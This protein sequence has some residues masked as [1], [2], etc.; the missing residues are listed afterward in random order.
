[1]LVL[2]HQHQHQQQVI[3]PTIPRF[4]IINITITNTTR[5]VIPMPEML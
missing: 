1:M 5:A 3:P 4:G 2:H